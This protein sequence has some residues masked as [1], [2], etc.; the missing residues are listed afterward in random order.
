MLAVY[1]RDIIPF[2]FMINP[3]TP[4]HGFLF[5]DHNGPWSTERLTKAMTRETSTKLGFRIT[6]QEF[7]HIAIAIDRKFI[8]GVN[9][10]P[11]DDEDEDDIHDLMAAHSTKLALA[12]YARMGGLT[13]SITPE[14][15]D[16]FR[17]IGDKWLRFYRQ[18]FRMPRSGITIGIKLGKGGGR[19]VT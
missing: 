17:T 15:I 10:E 14:S 18:A 5:A 6:T 8:R 4:R 1:L 2:R 7:R 19:G 3:N 12:R 13:R 9:A 16:G 11:D